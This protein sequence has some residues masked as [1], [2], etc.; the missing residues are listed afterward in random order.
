MFHLFA[1]KVAE[2][3]LTN[4]M[5]ISKVDFP[6]CRSISIDLPSEKKNMIKTCIW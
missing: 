5:A 2:L 3:G 6:F 1:F 4:F